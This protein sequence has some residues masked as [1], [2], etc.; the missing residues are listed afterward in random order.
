M[1]RL[2]HRIIKDKDRNDLAILIE[3]LYVYVNR[4]GGLDRFGKVEK[5]SLENIFSYYKKLYSLTQE[6]IN[7][8]WESASHLIR[9]LLNKKTSDVVEKVKRDEHVNESNLLYGKYWI[10]PPKG[11]KKKRYIKC[12]DHIQFCRENGEEFIESLGIDAF[13]YLHA[14]H[15]GNCNVVPII[16][17]AGGIIAEFVLENDKKVGRFQLAQCSLPWLKQR[18]VRMPIFKSHLRIFDPHEEYKSDRDGIY[19]IFRRPIKDKC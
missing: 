19:F 9:K 18:L 17:A 12:D 1:P 5:T 6:E 16:L 3:R 10:F 8:L 13:D 2:F 4:V 15:S 11:G 7:I 14:V